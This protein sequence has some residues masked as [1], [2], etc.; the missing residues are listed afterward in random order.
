MVAFTR[1]DYPAV[2]GSARATRRYGD[3][4]VYLSAFL[5][6]V[7]CDNHKS[8]AIFVNKDKQENIEGTPSGSITGWR[9]WLFRII[10]ITVIPALVLLGIRGMAHKRPRVHINFG[11]QQVAPQLSAWQMVIVMISIPYHCPI[12][13]FQARCAEFVRWQVA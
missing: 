6:T 2:I 1:V 13:T 4:T 9:L 5:G 10:A 3:S 11:Y 7:F 8:R 12:H